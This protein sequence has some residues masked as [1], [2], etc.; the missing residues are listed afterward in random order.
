[1]FIDRAGNDHYES[2][3]GGCG[4]GALGFGFLFDDDGSDTYH[5][6]AWSV[7]S[8]IFGGGALVDQGRQ[9]DVYLSEVF[10]QGVGG[11]RAM[12]IL[13][14]GGGDDL[15]RAN[16]P[17][18]SA[19]QT[20]GSFMAFSQGVGTGIRPYGLGGVGLLFDYGGNDRYEGGE[21]AQGGGYLWGIGMLRD[22]AG[23]DL[24]YGT[25]YAQGFAAHQAY[26]ALT[27]L[28]GDDI[29][30]G[31]SAATQGAAW[32]QSIAVLFDAQ[33]DDLYRAHSL[34]Q[35]AAA[36]QSRALLRDGAGNDRY[37]SFARDTQ[38]AAGGNRYHFDPFEPVYSLGILLDEQG[39]DIYSTGVENGEIVFR[40]DANGRHG[41]GVAGV[42]VDQ[43]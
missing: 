21:F 11:P 23:H 30:W 14:D 39:E 18:P 20:P 31:L 33:G 7:G 34:S 9:T 19:Y 16:G 10:S 6:A 17:I 41:R 32:D 40:R 2:R 3:L 24:Y 35:G 29:Y 37:W 22:E 4:A 8:A 38:G 36:Q 13:V 28:A 1:V 27:D 26:G 15:Y 43:P 25:R 12:G 5:C 42:V